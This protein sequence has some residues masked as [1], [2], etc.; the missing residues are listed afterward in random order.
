[1]L[2]LFRFFVV[3][4]LDSFD[5]L[6]QTQTT[7]IA[8]TTTTKT[9]PADTRAMNNDDCKND[10]EFKTA[11]VADDKKVVEK[12]EIPVVVL[13]EIVVGDAVVVGT[14]KAVV[15]GWVVVI[16]DTMYGWQPSDRS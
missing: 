13:E 2:R 3:Y 10:D 11:P 7:I 8:R 9:A 5:R 16:L 14:E 4:L 15:V 12:L 1:M 6:K